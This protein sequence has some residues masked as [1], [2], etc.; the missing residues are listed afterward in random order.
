M[1]GNHGR[2]AVNHPF[3]EAP[4]RLGVQPFCKWI[5]GYQAP[6][7]EQVALLRQF[8][9]A[10]REL[11]L[12]AKALLDT[13]NDEIGALRSLQLLEQVWLVEPRHIQFARLIRDGGNSTCATSAGRYIFRFPNQAHSRSHFIEGDMSNFYQFAVIAVFAR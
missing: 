13:G 2:V 9:A 1:I 12:V 8:M 11:N 5:D 4:Q 7:I 3:G 6:R 10:Y